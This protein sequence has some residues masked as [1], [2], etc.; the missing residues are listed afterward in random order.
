MHLFNKTSSQRHKL[1]LEHITHHKLAS[2][3]RNSH[4]VSERKNGVCVCDHLPQEVLSHHR[5]SKCCKTTAIPGKWSAPKINLQLD[6]K[7]ALNEVFK[8][9][10][11]KNMILGSR[12]SNS[13]VCASLCVYVCVCAYVCVK[14]VLQLAFLWQTIQH[15][16]RDLRQACHWNAWANHQLPS[17]NY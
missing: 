2:L 5:N 8:T 13:C 6:K 16:P 3:E 14:K 1:K 11:A 9:A 15:E 17:N 4:K 10:S 12:R 7:W